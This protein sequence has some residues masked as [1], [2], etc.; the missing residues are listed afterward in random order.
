MR[1]GRSYGDL[2]I[3]GIERAQSFILVLSSASNNSG[4]VSR[5]IERAVSKNKHIFTVRVEDVQPAPALELFVSSTQWIDAFEGR[6]APHIDQLAQQLADDDDV[7]TPEDWRPPTRT[8]ASRPPWRSP[9]VLGGGA[10]V[11]AALALGAFFLTRPTGDFTLEREACMNLSGA[12]GIAACDRAIASGKFS[13]SDAAY[14]L[15][16]RGYERQARNDLAGALADYSEAIRLDPR[17]AMAFN[18]RGNIY[19]DQGDYDRA[20]ADYDRALALDPAKPDPLASRGWVLSQ[21][22]EDERARQDF[23]KALALDPAPELKQ[24]LEAALIAGDK[25]FQACDDEQG[26]TAIA[27]CGRAIASGR[28][29]G[30]VLASLHIDI[31]PIRIEEVEPSPSLALFIAGT[32]WIDAFGG[33]LGAA[34]RLIAWRAYFRV[35]RSLLPLRFPIRQSARPRWVRRAAVAMAAAA[36][37]TALIFSWPFGGQTPVSNTPTVDP[38]VI[39]PSTV[40]E[41]VPQIADTGQ[42]TD[43]LVGQMPAGSELRP[44]EG[45]AMPADALPASPPAGGM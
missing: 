17:L 25:D 13:G 41:D 27:A 38:V 20:L 32:H 8:S 10:A 31:F 4:F 30:E 1:T 34:L 29:S 33:R 24:K 16:R 23:E 3:K 40:P 14:L 35:G 36:A 44:W 15:A 5:E 19:R 43:V 22:G 26:E 2:I 28:Y 42:D 18:N 11:L 37:L 7:A 6:L 21:K 9:Y 12:A 39:D 45:N